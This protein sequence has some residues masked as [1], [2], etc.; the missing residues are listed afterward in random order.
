MEIKSPYIKEVTPLY[1]G[2]IL[3]ETVGCPRPF[4]VF[5]L[6]L[7]SKRFWNKIKEIDNRIHI[8][9][10]SDN[11]YDSMNMYA[12]RSV[13]DYLVSW[14]KSET[15]SYYSSLIEK[16]NERNSFEFRNQLPL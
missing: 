15:D 14:K 11:K 9:S 6:F 3:I 5:N 16:N 8:L 12:L 1:K 2:C 7:D 10:I 13:R 4:K